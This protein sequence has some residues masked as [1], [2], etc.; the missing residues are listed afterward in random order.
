MNN[1]CTEAESHAFRVRRAKSHLFDWLEWSCEAQSE[2]RVLMMKILDAHPLRLARIARKLQKTE[3]LQGGLGKS[4]RSGAGKCEITRTRE[5]R[6][7]SR[8]ICFVNRS[9]AFSI[10]RENFL[11]VFYVTS[12]PP[13]SLIKEVVAT[14]ESAPSI[15]SKCHRTNLC[16]QK[17]T[18]TPDFPARTSQAAG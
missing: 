3:Q 8:R 10:K 16:T 7:I 17:H 5:E 13:F 18:Q 14:C 4:A 12:C 15:G 6:R 1:D 11:S 9:C 2:S